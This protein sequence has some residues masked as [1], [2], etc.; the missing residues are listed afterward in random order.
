MYYIIKSAVY[1]H[2][3]MWIGEDLEEGKAKANYFASNYDDG[4]HDY[5]VMLFNEPEH[6]KEFHWYE[7]SIGVYKG[8]DSRLVDNTEERKEREKHY[9]KEDIDQVQAMIDQ[10]TLANL[11]ELNQ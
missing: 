8:V 9:A 10:E 1:D 2:G 6:Y 3:V 4:H 5:T 7:K 11:R